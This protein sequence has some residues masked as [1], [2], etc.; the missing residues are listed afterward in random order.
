MAI[1]FTN[2]DQLT[3]LLVQ[4]WPEVVTG[5]AD[6][7][8]KLDHE[9]IKQ[10]LNNKTTTQLSKIRV[11]LVKKFE[12]I[13]P[14]YK[15][16][17][18]R[19]RSAQHDPKEVFVN[20]ILLLGTSIANKTPVEDIHLVYVSVPNET[21]GQNLTE[22]TTLSELTEVVKHLLQTSE[23]N[24]REIGVLKNEI[25]ALRNDK[26]SLS[27]EVAKLKAQLDIDDPSDLENSPELDPSI[28]LV[29]NEVQPIHSNL[30]EPVVAAVARPVVA[31][32]ENELQSN[33][34]EPVATIARPIT[35]AVARPVIAAVETA[36]VFIG[37]IQSPCTA[38]DIQTHITSKTTLTTKL[39]DIQK[40][41]IKSDKL[42]FKV[43]VPKNKLNL[44]TNP[45]VWSKGIRAELYKPQKPKGAKPNTN[46]RYRKTF[47]GPNP[48]STR[49]SRPS[50]NQNWR[51]YQPSPT[52]TYAETRLPLSD[53]WVRNSL[54][55][56]YQ[57]SYRSRYE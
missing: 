17:L 31:A 54:D 11:P 39:S 5:S 56:A 48:T 55:R 33:L 57:Y 38:Y 30:T 52:N 51:R 25:A 21:T 20:D 24:K 42:A 28:D 19:T 4:S 2:P 1:T 22:T 32:V 26:L 9:H 49:Q 40:L 18:A 6:S 34:T 15:A 14:S 23:T 53:E 37:N 12:E 50:Q 47:R 8:F 7:I 16:D 27:T 29:D 3:H 13:N 43:A 45:S 46:N 36:Y 41:D 44:L 10:I 35:A